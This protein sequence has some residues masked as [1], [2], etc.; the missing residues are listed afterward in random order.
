MSDLDLDLLERLEAAVNP[1]GSHP[2]YLA[3]VERRMQ[4]VWNHAPGLIADAKR[5]RELQSQ[6]L[7][8][9]QQDIIDFSFDGCRMSSDSDEEQ[10][11]VVLAGIDHIARDSGWSPAAKEGEG[12]GSL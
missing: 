3:T 12:D 7:H 11:A 8:L 10:L 6:L 5:L 2:P 1:A 4:L 9:A